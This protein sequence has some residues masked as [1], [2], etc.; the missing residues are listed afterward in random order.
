MGLKGSDVAKEAAD[1]I[2]MDDNF[3]SIVVGIEEGR[4]IFDNLKK[5]VAYTLTHLG[6]EIF[7]VLCNLAFSLP[8]GISS[9]LILCI[10]LGTELAPAISLAYE[11]QESDIMHRPP[12]SQ[13]DRM[14]SFP[15][16]SYSYLQA[17]II[18]T[19]ACFLTFFSVF[20]YHGVPA[21]LLPLSSDTYWKSGAPDLYIDGELYD[22][23]RQVNILAEAQCAWFITLVMCQM[24]HIWMCKS[25]TR[26]LFTHKAKNMVTNYGVL[27]SIGICCLLVYLPPLQPYIGTANVHGYFW[28]PWIGSATVLWVWNEGRK[29]WVRTHPQ[30]FVAR[31]ISW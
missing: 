14:V 22:A 31:N 5:T 16:L 30:G 25:R 10:D 3:A 1:V 11:Y 8:L 26:S 2:L 7:P 21:S 24:S 17:G 23:D 19:L 18:E 4:L 15:V 12:R 29:A 9:I 20:W 13:K 6:P 27:I 28:L